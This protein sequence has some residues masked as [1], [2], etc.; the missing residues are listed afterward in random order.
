MSDYVT[1]Q[2]NESYELVE[3]KS[4]FIANTYFVQN[5]EQ[6]EEVIKECKKKF[7]DARHNCYAYRIL[8]DQGII[9][10]SSD[11]GEPSGTAG[12]PM[13]NIL[14]KNNLVNV[15]VIVTRYFGGILLGT[16]GLVKAYSES[17]QNALAKSN[18]AKVVRGIELEIEIEYSEFEKVKY[19]FRK[20]DAK[21]KNVQYLENI[22]C[23]IEMKKE[24]LKDFLNENDEKSLKIV[25]FTVLHEINILESIEK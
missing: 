1:I 25:N 22:I 9:E 24:D 23:N 8:N 2:G 15:L 4:K 5:K 6:A 17:T 19:Y 7:Y 20:K 3:K 18:F 14:V 16:G 12:A 13:L 10:K 21:I 11:D